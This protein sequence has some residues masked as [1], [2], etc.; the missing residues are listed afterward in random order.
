MD[1]EFYVGIL[2]VV[3]CFCAIIM[4]VTVTNLSFATKL[5]NS[6]KPLELACAYNGNTYKVIQSCLTLQMI[7][8]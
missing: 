6:D 7:K 2:G 1:K 5:A 3:I 4:A 8:E